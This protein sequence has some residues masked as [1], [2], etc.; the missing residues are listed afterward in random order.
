MAHR[1][2]EG[3]AVDALILFARVPQLG[4]VKSR[5]AADIGDAAALAAYEELG[6]A[7]WHEVTMARRLMAARAIVAF[8]PGGESTAMRG[9]L[10]GAD[11]Y[12]EQGAGD[13]GER[14]LDAIDG[15]LRR[16]ARRV[17]VVGSDCPT[18]SA[19]TLTSAF[20]RLENADLVVGPATDGGYYLIGVTRRQPSL[21]QDI[22][23]SSERTLAATLAR[24][25][26]AGLRVAAL[27][28]LTDVDTLAE[29]ME[30]REA[31]RAQPGG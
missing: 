24:A 30:W 31:G 27:E 29:W 22:P 18:L 12:V 20:A 6:K 16:G 5:L 9:W 19:S 17:V 10:A 8:T 28:T 21:F 14:M 23:W 1:E 7:C 26:T 11:E 13:L 2:D 4:R 25:D 3:G 15:Q